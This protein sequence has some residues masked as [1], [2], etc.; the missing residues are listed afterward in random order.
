M[1]RTAETNYELKLLTD[2]WRWK[3]PGKSQVDQSAPKRAGFTLIF[4]VN[5]P[6][7]CFKASTAISALTTGTP[8]NI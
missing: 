2:D 4:S 6:H 1:S 7:V 5:I 8:P 3:G